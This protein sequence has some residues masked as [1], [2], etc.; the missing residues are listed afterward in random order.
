VLLDWGGTVDADGEPWKFRVAALL[1][2]EGVVVEAERFDRA[3]YA[4]DDALVGAVP[5]AL[6]LVGVSRRLLTG[7][8]RGL[9]VDD[10]A[11]AERVAVA[12]AEQSR[13]AV[14]RNATVLAALAGRY[15]LGLV[16]N[17]YGNLEAVCD[18]CGVRDLFRII[19]DSACVGCEKPDPRIFG[20]ALDALGVSPAEAVFVGDS[21]PRD[22]AGARGVGMPHIWLVPATDRRRTACCPAD[23]VV[24]S[25]VELEG[26]LL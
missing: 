19:M 18:D 23:P 21:L 22:M 7:L 24:H 10:S 1:A 17:F 11:L 5:H 12:F 9:G 2:A 13:A 26:L 20:S 8:T 6:S 14:R 25:L 16:S 3:F 15:R 4:A